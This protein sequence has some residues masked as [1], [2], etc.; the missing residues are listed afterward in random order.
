MVVGKKVKV[1]VDVTELG[2]KGGQARAAN[3]SAAELSESSR[4]AS[5]ARW[6]AYYADHPDKLAARK[7]RD[8]KRGNVKRGRPPKKKAKV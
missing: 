2:R 4:Q 8:A 1:I 3:L 7:E 5:V 6:A